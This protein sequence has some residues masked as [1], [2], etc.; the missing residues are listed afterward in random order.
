MTAVATLDSLR[1]LLRDTSGLVIGPDKLYLLEI[2]LTALLRREG[3]H[4]LDSLDRLLRTQRGGSLA[5]DVAEAMTT[6]ETSF[7]RDGHPFEHLRSCGLPRL[8]AARPAG[9]RIRIWSAAASSGQEAYSIAM[10]LAE[11]AIMRA[12]RS[13]LVLGTDIARAPLAQARQGLY[14]QLQVQR[15]LS[16]QQLGDHFTPAGECWQVAAPLLATCEF[17]TWNLLDDLAPLGHFD[18][19]FC[20]N[21]LM[22]LDTATKARVLGAIARRLSPDGLLYLGASET[23]SGLTPLLKPFEQER[24][25][26]QPIRAMAGALPLPAHPDAC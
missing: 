8:L 7:F 6:N 15:G 11:N 1:R 10:I 21:V 18:I 13:A 4:D 17:C 3:L 23:A 5:C 26:Y 20:R 19:V 25:V 14:T 2:R 16:G 24:T 12:G 22:Y 9:R